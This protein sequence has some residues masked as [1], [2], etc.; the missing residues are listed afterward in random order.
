[1]R[2]CYAIRFGPA[3]MFSEADGDTQL[4]I[5]HAVSE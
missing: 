2:L 4:Y 1:M 5:I 3:M